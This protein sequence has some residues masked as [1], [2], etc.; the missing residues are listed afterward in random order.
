MGKAERAEGRVILRFVGSQQGKRELRP[1][2]GC[3]L[4]L[5]ALP[6][7]RATQLCRLRPG[8]LPSDDN[9]FFL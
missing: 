3:L 6:P 4:A 9:G 7:S 8:F 2:R 1:A 5:F